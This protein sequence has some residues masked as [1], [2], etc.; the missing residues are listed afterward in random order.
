[1]FSHKFYFSSHWHKHY[2]LFLGIYV[3]HLLIHNMATNLANESLWINYHR[4]S[5]LSS[6]LMSFQAQC[7]SAESIHTFY[8]SH[9]TVIMKQPT[10]CK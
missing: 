7:F 8:S 5:H 9:Q 4:Y 1:M 2:G 10:M 6:H 3:H